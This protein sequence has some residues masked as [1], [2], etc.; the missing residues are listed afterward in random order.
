[1]NHDT[2]MAA[3]QDLR[4]LVICCMSMAVRHHIGL[5]LPFYKLELLDKWKDK[6]L[7]D[8]NKNINLF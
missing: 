1:M 3:S 8:H 6:Q 7:K 2:L 4:V 5:Q